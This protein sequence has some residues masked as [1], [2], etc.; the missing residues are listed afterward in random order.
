MD[1]AQVRKALAL[2]LTLRTDRVIPLFDLSERDGSDVASM[3]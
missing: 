1:S 3:E 2:S